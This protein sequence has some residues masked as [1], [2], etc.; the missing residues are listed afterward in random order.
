MRLPRASVTLASLLV[1]ALSAGHTG[2]A[3]AQA[4]P[5]DPTADPVM[6]NA[7]FLSAHPDLNN[8]LRGLDAY[9]KADFVAAFQYFMRAAHYADKPAQ[10][11]VAEMYALGQGTSR[12]PVLAY[13]WMDLAAERGYPDFIA[14][15]EKMWSGLSDSERA[16]ALEEGKAIYT[17]YGDDVANPRLAREM[18]RERMKVVGSRTGYTGNA[19]INVPVP[20]MI[21]GVESTPSITIDGSQFY[22]D[23]FWEPRQYQAWLDA[24]WK[25][26]RGGRVEVGALKQDKSVPASRVKD[27][28]DAPGKP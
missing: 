7:G 28:K 15:R 27:K 16:R 4:T 2:R 10:A 19:K 20:G 21:G 8:R 12:D 26:P 5:K 25:E 9:R 18:R 13:A 1:L 11:M 3:K 24:Q 22:A 23:K 6:L 17:R 14:M